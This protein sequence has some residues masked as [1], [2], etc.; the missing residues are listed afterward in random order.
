MKTI[1]TYSLEMLSPSKLKLQNNSKGMKI[2][3]CEIKQFQFNRFLYQIVGQEYQWEDKLAWSDD[4]WRSFAEKDNLRT[5]VGYYKGSPAGYFELEKQKGNIIELAYFGLLPK[6]IG[7][8]LGGYLLSQAV[9]TAWE[10]GNPEKVW[11]HTCT[12]D[13]PHAL[14][15]YQ[16]RGFEIFDIVT[17]N[18]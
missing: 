6:F 4:K 7:M 8:G 18:I 1:T 3:E 2:I 14:Q 15:N 9:K 17:E 12:L 5:W 13:H 16:K 11:V 10:W